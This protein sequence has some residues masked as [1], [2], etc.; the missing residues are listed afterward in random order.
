MLGI[1]TVRFRASRR[2]HRSPH[3]F[4]EIKALADGGNRGKRSKKYL[5]DSYDDL[6][7]SSR[8]DRSWKQYRMTQYK[9]KHVIPEKLVG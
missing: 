7:V 5:P 9:V 8:E 4:P 6:N 3:T 1:G 2:C